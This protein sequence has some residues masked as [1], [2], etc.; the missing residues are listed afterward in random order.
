MGEAV[1]GT[2][3]RM[4]RRAGFA[5]GSE[6]WAAPRS[7]STASKPRRT[8]CSPMT[9]SSTRTTATRTR[10]AGNTNSTGSTGFWRRPH[11]T[12]KRVRSG[13]A[14]AAPV[15]RTRA[16][17]VCRARECGDQRW[18]AAALDQVVSCPVSVDTGFAAVS[19][20]AG[21]GRRSSRLATSAVGRTSSVA[22]AASSRD[23]RR[24]ALPPE[25]S[26]MIHENGLLPRRTTQTV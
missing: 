23:G 5:D 15:S 22:S 11:P 25:G 24:Q 14:A 17:L 12:R 1:I 18:P 10:A 13:A 20:Q 7:D 8:S 26:G 3:R 21:S 2:V 19:T 4:R 6:V 16:A 9:A